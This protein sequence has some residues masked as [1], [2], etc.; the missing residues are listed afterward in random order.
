MSEWPSEWRVGPADWDEAVML[1]DGPQLVVAGPGAGK[2]EFLTRRALHLIGEV[3]VDPEQLLL[4]SFSRR[5]AS[6]LRGRVEEGLDRS[7]TEISASTFH[8]LAFRL[9]ELYAPDALGWADMPRL[10]TGPEHV[11]F[12]HRMLVAEDADTWPLPFRDLLTTQTFAREVRDF[13]S[14]CR[15]QLIDPSEL[16]VRAAQRTEWR[17]LPR[18][19]ARYLEELRERGRI[20]YGT[21]QA[22]AVGLLDDPDV[23]AA[24]GDRFRYILVDEYQDTTIAQARLLERLYRPHRNLTVAGDPYESI[25]SF[26]GTELA[27]VGEFPDRF[28]AADGAPAQRV[29]LTT[30]F[31]VPAGILDAAVR[32]TTGGDLPGG[33][34]P[35]DAA[36]GTGSVEAFVFDQHSQEAEWIAT[37]VQRTHLLDAVPFR[38]MAV[39]VRSKRRLLPE[40]SR[41]LERR[42]IAHEVPNARLSDHAAVRLILDCVVAATEAGGEQDRAMRRIL[43]GP[44]FTLPLGTLRELER[45]RARLDTSWAALLRSSVDGAEQLA[46]LI[47]DG[48]WATDVPAAAGF[49]TLWSTLPNLPDLV[50]DPGREGDRAAW[51]SLAQVLA[52]LEDRDPTASLADYVRLAEDEEFEATPLLGFRA[53][54]EDRLTLTTLHQAKGLEFDLVIIADAVE[55]VFPDLRPRESLLGTRHLSPGQ[56]ADPAEYLRFRLQEEMR[57]A[58]TAMCRARRRVVWTGTAVGAEG[59]EGGPSRFLG[60]V[61]EPGRAP[62]GWEGDERAVVTPLEAEAWLRR[63]LRDP[64]RPHAERLAALWALAAGRQWGLRHPAE[65][66]GVA[67][68]GPDSGLLPAELKL[69]PSQAQSYLTCPRR[70]AFERRLHVGDRATV[71]SEFG[72]L[73]HDVLERAEQEAVDGD[74]PHGSIDGALAA[75]AELWDGAPYGGGAWAEGWRRHARHTLE[76]LY[77]HWPSV[78]HP[79]A[80]EHDLELE[81]GGVPWRGRADRI[82]VGA[83]GTLKVVDYKTSKSPV[84]QETAAVSVQ[85]GFYLMAAAADPELAALGQPAAA[86]LWYPASYGRQ[87]VAIRPLD[88]ERMD[89]VTE[90]M[91]AAATGIASE[92]WR[93]TPGSHCDRCRLR[94]VCPAWP[95]GREAYQS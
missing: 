22:D 70:Y 31:R 71:Y 45:Q 16:E 40:L 33:A 87:S 42:G 1:V 47:A 9:L 74:E 54:D 24:V 21:L 58:Y 11:A 89:E 32:V 15:E 91:A 60:M 29:V 84:S 82:E 59:G 90:A 72:S 92:D 83:D 57:L 52:Q 17:A 10:L 8:S 13:V 68:R 79:V 53:P 7:F 30:S 34:G 62:A 49:W 3:G 25:Y 94:T 81:V 26:R 23:V 18:F 20:D 63:L 51:S 19:L 93:P 27:N 55:G 14:R 69:S 2:T 41:A 28:P 56:P 36:D 66:A 5:S 12:V 65:F 73:I 48:V 78:G 64:G 86:E 43:L 75:L 80:L 39:L 85:L 37:E 77:E 46:A 6:D 95:E 67:E 61:A 76:H 4:L 38:D 88:V 44:L 35:V 50:A